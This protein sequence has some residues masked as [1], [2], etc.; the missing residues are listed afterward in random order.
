[1][2][3]FSSRSLRRLATCHADLQA[4]F[5]AVIAHVDCSILEGHRPRER[6]QAAL[7]RGQSTLGWPDSKHNQCPSLAIDAAPW[8][9]DWHDRDRF[10]LF[11]G[12][13]LG[14]A[15]QK[16]IDL[17]WGGD[18]NGDFNVRDNRFDDLV[19]FELEGPRP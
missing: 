10:H 11:G 12:V 16:G 19:H 13:V 9:I 18:W 14:I 1:M 5:H 6:Q 8:P 7:A 4:V 15:K 2:P 17:R 3:H